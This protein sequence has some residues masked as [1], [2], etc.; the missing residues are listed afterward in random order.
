[1]LVLPVGL[2]M[3]TDDPVGIGGWSTID[4][5]TS[6]LSMKS[7]VKSLEQTIFK[8]HVADWVNSLWEVDTSWY[9]TISVGPVVLE[10]L[11]VELVANNDNFL[12]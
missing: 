5:S 9:L 6:N 11:H 7:I 2:S 12:G 10:T 1:M 8:I 4:V 3:V